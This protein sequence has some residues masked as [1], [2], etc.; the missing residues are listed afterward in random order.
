[1]ARKSLTVMKI[2]D[3]VIAIIILIGSV[4]EIATIST[5]INN[6]YSLDGVIYKDTYPLS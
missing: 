4:V 1:M 3:L 2:V 5:E 6:A